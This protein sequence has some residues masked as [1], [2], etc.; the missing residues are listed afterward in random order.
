VGKPPPDRAAWVEGL[1]GVTSGPYAGGIRLQ[2][3][4]DARVLTRRGGATDVCS[5][6]YE[7]LIKLGCSPGKWSPTKERPGSE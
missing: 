7:H 1:V 6:V 2:V 4:L 5:A 3:F